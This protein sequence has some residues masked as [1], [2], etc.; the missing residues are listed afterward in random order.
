[1]KYRII[2]SDNE[3]AEDVKEY[4]VESDED[5]KDVVKAMT[6]N[7]IADRELSVADVESIS[8]EDDVFND[9][10]LCIIQ[11]VED[12][13][14]AIWA[15]TDNPKLID[16]GGFIGLAKTL[17]D[18]FYISSCENTDEYEEFFRNFYNDEE[19]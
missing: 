2:V 6:L 18:D 11:C 10:Y 9:R 7:V 1:M 12:Y 15:S 19:E 8:F 14:I 3:N 5:V 13:H 4:L 17:D 16:I